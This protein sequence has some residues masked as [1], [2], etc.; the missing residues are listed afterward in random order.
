MSYEQSESKAY[1]FDN[2]VWIMLDPEMIEVTG[3]N[4]NEAIKDKVQ[5]NIIISNLAG[6]NAFPLTPKLPRASLAETAGHW[7]AHPIP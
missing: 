7:G 2:I 6:G 5:P 4:G 1:P 3:K